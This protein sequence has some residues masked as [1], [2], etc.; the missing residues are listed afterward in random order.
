MSFGET[1]CDLFVLLRKCNVKALV[2]KSTICWMVYIY[3]V[4]VLGIVKSVY[5]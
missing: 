5:N 1:D 3:Q 4:L 2:I